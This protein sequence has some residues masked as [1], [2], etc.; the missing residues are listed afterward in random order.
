M[1]TVAGLLLWLYLLPAVLAWVAASVQYHQPVSV[2][3]PRQL[4]LAISSA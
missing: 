3:P 2:S 4:S 1:V